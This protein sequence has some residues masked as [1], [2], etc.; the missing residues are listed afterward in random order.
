DLEASAP[1]LDLEQLVPLP[2]CLPPRLAFDFDPAVALAR[3]V[4]R[5]STLADDAF[6]LAFVTSNQK[7]LGVVEGL[8]KTNWTADLHIVHQVLKT[9]APLYQRFGPQVDPIELQNIE[10]PGAQSP[11]RKPL[12]AEV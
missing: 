1:A 3:D 7:T 6:K 11:W 4:W 10:S 9:L 12:G 5:R 2:V 8:G